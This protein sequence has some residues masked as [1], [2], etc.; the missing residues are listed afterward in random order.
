[1]WTEAD[2]LA[3]AGSQDMRDSGSTL[4]SRIMYTVI[5]K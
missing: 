1:M 3:P 5:H 2:L 4:N